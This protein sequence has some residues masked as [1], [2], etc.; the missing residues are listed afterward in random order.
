[1]FTLNLRRK[2]VFIA[3]FFILG[4][5]SDLY[6]NPISINP[7][8]VMAQFPSNSVQRIFQDKYGYIWFGTLDVL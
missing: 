2:S 8:P 4:V 5:I 3:V 6:P 1:M 7:I